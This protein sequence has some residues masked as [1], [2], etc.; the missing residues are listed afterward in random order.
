[1]IASG[2][3][4]AGG[5]VAQRDLV[6]DPESS[7]RVGLIADVPARRRGYR[8]GLGGPSSTRDRGKLLLA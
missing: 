7:I 2:Q 8:R 6:I 4:Q 5:V 1:L 3:R